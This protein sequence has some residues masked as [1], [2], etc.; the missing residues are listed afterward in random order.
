MKPLQVSSTA[1]VRW[2][3]NGSK[4]PRHH[5]NYRHNLV[6]LFLQKLASRKSV[7]LIQKREKQKAIN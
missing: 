4:H 7:E 3:F 5:N 6:N 1:Q 2:K